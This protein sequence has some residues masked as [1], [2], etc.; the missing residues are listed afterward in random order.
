MSL[1]EDVSVSSRTLAKAFG[2]VS[3]KRILSNEMAGV[4]S[5]LRNRSVE[6]MIFD[7]DDASLLDVHV[8]CRVVTASTD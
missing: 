4:S 2:S 5:L 1:N 8:G 6:R 7:G 3:T